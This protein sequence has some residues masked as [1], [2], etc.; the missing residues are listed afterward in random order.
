MPNLLALDD[1]LTLLAGIAPVRGDSERVALGGALGRVLA[2][3][4]IAPGDIPAF[5]NSAVDG[6]AVMGR[7][8]QGAR[9][10]LVGTS[11]AGEPFRGRLG[12]GQAIRIA[13]GAVVPD[14]TDAVVMQE[15]CK[16]AGETVTI[17]IAPALGAH[18]RRAG[19]DVTAGTTVLPA[20]RR[21]SAADISMLAALGIAHPQVRRNLR[22]AIAS[23]GTELV[24]G[25]SL[26]PGQI[27][28]SNRPLLKTLLQ[29]YPVEIMDLG[30]LPDDAETTRMRL[31]DASSEADLILTTGGVSVGARDYVRETVE[32]EG[33]V[34]FWRLAIKPG[35]PLLL[36][37]LGK[38]PLLGLPGNPVSTFMTFN[39]MFR[40]LAYR[41]MGSPYP[42]PLRFPVQSAFAYRKSPHLREFARVTLERNGA[43]ILTAMPFRSQLSNLISSLLDSD[44]LL[45]LPVGIEGIAPG[46]I[47][48]FIPWTSFDRV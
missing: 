28:D 13:T 16:V 33:E 19:Q 30:I 37:R 23:T 41:L 36:G 8:E 47:V 18:C 42:A 6:Y 5:D 44:G 24:E 48:D 22:V 2:E 9:F 11:S 38:T 20:G 26:A 10:A 43:G 32:A 31:L 4:A 45:D 14:D 25:G 17:G 3:P 12:P 29:A 35:K 21:L 46:D 7:L 15:D 1:A 27:H 40:P 34:L 39:L